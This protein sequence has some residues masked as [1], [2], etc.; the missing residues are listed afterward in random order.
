MGAEEG[1]ANL[2]CQGLGIFFPQLDLE[3]PSPRTWAETLLLA[4]PQA[5][6]SWPGSPHHYEP[7]HPR[8][9]GDLCVVRGH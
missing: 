9:M 3:A 5:G 4:S 1:V 7:L 6:W 8:A 2:Q